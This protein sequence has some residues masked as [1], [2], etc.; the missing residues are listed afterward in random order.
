MRRFAEKPG[1]LTSQIEKK[2]FFGKRGRDCHEG[3]VNPI[4]SPTYIHAPA[5]AH[6]PD[7]VHPSLT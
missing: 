3:D 6:A 5:A 7:E 2:A 4:M 1:V